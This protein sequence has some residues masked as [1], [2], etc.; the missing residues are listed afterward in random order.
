MTRRQRKRAKAAYL[1]WLANLCRKIA[2]GKNRARVE[3]ITGH[4]GNFSIAMHTDDRDLL[5][6][7][8][9]SYLAKRDQI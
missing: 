2:N 9:R 7:E 3:A 5:R 1:T 6:R 8:A 4:Y